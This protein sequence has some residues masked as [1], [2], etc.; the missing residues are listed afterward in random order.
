MPVTGRAVSAAVLLVV[1]AG[2]A[3]LAVLV[4]YGFMRVYGDVSG[5]A[6]DG[7]IGG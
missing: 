3:V 7:L 5:T 6:F 2:L 4:H 1:G